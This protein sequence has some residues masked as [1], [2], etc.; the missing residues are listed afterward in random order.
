MLLDLTSN[1]AALLLRHLERHI[2]HLET[3]LDPHDAR[4]VQLTLSKEI[5]ALEAL[6]ERLR[7]APQEP[8]PDVE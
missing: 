2:R 1:E 7:E 5:A 3:E 6:C 4:D 8:L